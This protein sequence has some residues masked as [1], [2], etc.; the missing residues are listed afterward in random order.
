MVQAETPFAK[1][2]RRCLVMHIFARTQLQRRNDANNANA[3]NGELSFDQGAFHAVAVEVLNLQPTEVKLLIEVYDNELF[4]H[5]EGL[6]KNQRKNK[7]SDVPKNF[8]KDY[9][10][11]VEM[12]GSLPQNEKAT[13]SDLLTEIFDGIAESEEWSISS[14][15]LDKARDWYCKFHGSRPTANAIERVLRFLFV[16]TN[17]T[18]KALNIAFPKYSATEN[19]EEENDDED[20]DLE[21][22]VKALDG[23]VKELE[24]KNQSLEEDLDNMANENDQNAAALAIAT[25]EIEVLKEQIVEKEKAIEELRTVND[26]K[27]EE[28][29]ELK[30]EIDEIAEK[31]VSLFIGMRAFYCYYNLLTLHSFSPFLAQSG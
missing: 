10:R 19:D 26:E 30:S 1:H 8:Y 17:P 14:E 18:V 24:A 9:I 28:N 31:R 23:K 7:Y 29:A 15:Q 21:E 11:F 12:V 13:L 3:N 16:S 22:Q 5:I 20:E 25:S 6:S 2:V 4:S 27:N